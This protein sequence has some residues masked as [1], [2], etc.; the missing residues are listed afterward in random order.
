MPTPLLS[1]SFPETTIDYPE[2]DGEPMAESDVQRNYLT[3]AVEALRDHFRFRPDCYVSGNLLIYY[4][5]GNPRA[6]VAPDCF[7]VFGVPGHDRRIYK[8]WEEG[9]AVPS[10]VLEVTSR[11][12]RAEDCGSKRGVYAYLGVREYWQYDP[13]GDYLRPPLRGWVRDGDQY[14]EIQR[15]LGPDR[16]FALLSEVLGLELHLHAG[17]L[18]FR[19][20]ATS[21]WLR[22]YRES[23]DDRRAAEAARAAAERE[24]RALRER[25]AELEARFDPAFRPLVRS[26]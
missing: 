6:A 2:T 19:D 18:R 12:T 14:R 22:T 17:R 24:S 16:D 10:F 7:V 9:G 25:L 8:V 26:D 21:A 15:G 4:D 5:E 20:P 11:S 23:A 13:T 3:Y 1:D